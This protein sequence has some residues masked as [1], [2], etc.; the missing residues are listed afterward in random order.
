MTEVQFANRLL[1]SIARPQSSVYLAYEY[2]CEHCSEADLKRHIEEY[3]HIDTSF[4]RGIVA[5]HAAVEKMLARDRRCLKSPATRGYCP[6]WR[7]LEAHHQ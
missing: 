5:H 3:R 4:A 6:G 1:G 2:L 7:R